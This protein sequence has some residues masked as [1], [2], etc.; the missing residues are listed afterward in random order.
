LPSDY[1]LGDSFSSQDLR[2]T[3]SF[4]SQ[5]GIELRLIGEAFNLFNVSN[6][7]TT[8]TTWSCRRPSA[9]RTSAWGRTFGS[10]GPRAFQLAA[11]VSF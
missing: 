10:G 1:Q 11:R 5:R 8:T 4:G 6:L 2:V 3:K 9:R 7:T